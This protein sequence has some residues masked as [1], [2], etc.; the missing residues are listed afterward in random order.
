MKPSLP[1][2]TLILRVLAPLLLGLTAGWG[3]L[4]YSTINRTIL[5]GFDRKL[6]ALSGGAA[7]FVDAEAHAAYQRRRTLSALCAGPG[8]QLL[9]CDAATGELLAIDPEKGGARPLG[10]PLANAPRALAYDAH[11][12]ELLVLSAAGDRVER[13]A[14]APPQ[15]RPAI[16]PTAPLDGLFVDG[17][18]INAWRGVQLLRVDPETGAGTPLPAALPESVAALCRLGPEEML[19]G[20]SADGATLLLLDRASGTLLSRTTLHTREESGAESRPPPPL[21]TLA[22]SGGTL[23]T[24]GP[25]L[26]QIEKETGRLDW[27]A[28]SPG[29]LSEADPFYER[30]RTPF[31]A[32]RR[33]A[34]LTFL[35]TDIYLGDDKI[36]Y[37]L[38][39]TEGENYSMPGADDSIPNPEARDGAERA[40]FL[41]RPWVSPVQQWKQWGLL[42]TS[43]FPIKTADGRTVALAGADVDITVIR[44]KTRWAMFAVFFV[45]VASLIAAVLVSLLIARSLTR[46]LR[47]LKESALRIA[48]G[49]YRTAP[50]TR[51]HRETGAL[52][53]TLNLLGER[54]DDEARRSRSY[55]SEL[56]AS[57]R[58]TTLVRALED[59]AA[60]G[61][62]QNR[63]DS[64]SERRAS[65]NCWRGLD[66]LFWHGPSLADPVAAACLRA[67]LTCLARS[68]LASPI[69]ALATPSAML[70][71]VPALAACAR[72]HTT[73]HRLHYATRRPSRLRVGTAVQVLDGTGHL[74]LAADEP[75]EWLDPDP[76]APAAH[77][78]STP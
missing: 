40:Q 1:L 75:C 4:V 48:A 31:I 38:D 7:A 68:L 49:Y 78:E 66:G 24:A 16:V 39:G 54:L 18:E 65:G 32:I 22:C 12:H 5:D 45:G 23:F 63:D 74:D 8:G 25:A 44:E 28:R 13:Y 14:L 33:A 3:W 76:D 53:T 77:R 29:Y 26:A 15:T 47:D 41:G 70:A 17:A 30:Y 50:A 62:V 57:R 46:P 51:G 34:R 27:S 2:Q 52:A 64:A 58:Q 21:H 10:L 20:L 71:S 6:L 55:Q 61:T 43:S 35:Y 59:L 72:W 42:K 37:V 73:T 11:H 67:R 69:E 36:Y 60:R 56:H 9:G 19:A